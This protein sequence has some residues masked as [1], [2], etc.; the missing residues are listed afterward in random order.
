M[1]EGSG[2]PITSEMLR[3]GLQVALL[4]LPAPEIWQ[5]PEGLALVGP[6]AFGYDIPYQP[7]GATL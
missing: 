1:E 4:V 6:K 3:Y 5:T 7:I 2:T